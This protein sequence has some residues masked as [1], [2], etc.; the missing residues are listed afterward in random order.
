M[1]L[2]YDGRLVSYDS[3]AAIGVVRA[4]GTFLQA[5]V[6]GDDLTSASISTTPLADKFLF[7]FGTKNGVIVASELQKY[8]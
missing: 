7:A 4:V 6:Y 2:R 3:T 8:T 1:S 5:T